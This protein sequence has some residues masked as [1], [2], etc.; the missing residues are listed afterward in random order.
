MIN[1]RKLIITALS[2]SALIGSLVL[3]APALAWHP[4]GHITKFVANDTTGSKSIDANSTADAASA[5]PG[6]ILTYTVTIRNDGQPDKSGNNDMASVV[7]TDTLPDDV[8]LVSTPSQRVIKET[9]SG[10]IQPGKSIVKTYK[11]KVTSTTDGASLKNTAC[12]TG[13][14]TVNDNKQQGCDVAYASVK[15]EKPTPTPAPTPTPTPTPT[16]QQPTKLPS[17][18]P[19]AA[20]GSLTGLGALSYAASSYFRSK[21]AISRAIGK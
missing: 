19:E 13:N 11:V 17:T 3:P 7:L 5:K 2:A 10:V 21:K 4:V 20:L 12:F 8:E 16:P 15:V 9:I 1:N 18:G 6:D 14:S